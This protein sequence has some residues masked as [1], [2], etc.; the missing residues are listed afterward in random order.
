MHIDLW[1][2]I[3]AK[4]SRKVLA[5]HRARHFEPGV[6]YSLNNESTNEFLI[7]LTAKASQLAWAERIENVNSDLHDSV[8]YNQYPGEHYRFLKAITKIINPQLIVE[9]GTYT[10]MGTRA[11]MQGQK[12]GCVYTYD[13]IGWQSFPTHLQQKDFEEIR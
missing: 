8:Y 6:I 2:K 3:Y 4:V 5:K 13:L 9:I 11:L 1:R 10:G 7:Q 12:V